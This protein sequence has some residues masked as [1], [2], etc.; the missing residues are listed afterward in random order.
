MSCSG[1]KGRSECPVTFVLDIFGDKWSL[2]IVRDLMLRGRCTYGEFLNAGD[3]IAT[4]ILADRL[5]CLELKGIIHK[6]RDPKSRR[7]YLYSLTKKGLDLAPIILEMIRWSGKHDP[8]TG[9]RKE[10][11]KRLRDDFDGII[12]D[13]HSG[14]VV[15]K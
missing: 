2:L 9:A 3:G 10:F 7:R 6:S 4:N 13:I 12:S 1:K 11:L 14:I 5:R 8:A 15:I